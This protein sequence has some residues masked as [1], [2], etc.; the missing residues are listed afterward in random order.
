MPVCHVDT[1]KGT[2]ADASGPGWRSLRFGLKPDRPGF[3]M[4]E[5]RIDAGVDHILRNRHHIEAVHVIEG[6]GEIED[7][8]GRQHVGNPAAKALT[9]STIS[10]QRVRSAPGLSA[11]TCESRIARTMRPLRARTNQA[12]NASVAAISTRTREQVAIRSAGPRPIAPP[13]RGIGANGG[14]PARPNS[15]R[16]MSAMVEKVI[17]TISAKARG[18]MATCGSGRL[19]STGSPT[20]S[21]TAAAGAPIRSGTRGESPA[22]IERS[23]GT[24]APIA[25]NARCPKVLRPA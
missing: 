24:Q 13:G 5:T 14:M 1:I 21:P 9:P 4:T 17:R 11:A 8:P 18:T 15:P 7:C 22:V 12:T 23:A 10:L 19:R 16:V 25:K 6:E 20:N 3:T 2:R